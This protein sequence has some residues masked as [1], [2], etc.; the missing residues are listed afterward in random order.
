MEIN[1]SELRRQKRPLWMTEL[2]EESVAD[3]L[4]GGGDIHSDRLALDW[5]RESGLEVE[6]ESA[7]I[8]LEGSAAEEDYVS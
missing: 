3:M 8:L 5:A 7:R 1:I 6:D 4:G 2:D